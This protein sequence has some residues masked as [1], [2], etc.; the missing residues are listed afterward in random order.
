[1]DKVAY[2]QAMLGVPTKR[3]WPWQDMLDQYARELGNCPEMSKTEWYKELLG[4]TYSG[5][6]EALEMIEAI[7]KVGIPDFGLQMLKKFFT[8]S[9]MPAPDTLPRAMRQV[10]EHLLDTGKISIRQTQDKEKTFRDMLEVA[11]GISGDYNSGIEVRFG[12]RLKQQF[13]EYNWEENKVITAGEQKVRPDFICE[14]LT[15]SIE[16]DGLEFHQDRYS[17]THDRK[18]SRLMQLA[19]YYHLQFSGPELSIPDG[20]T[21]ALNEIAFFIE[22]RKLGEE[23]RYSPRVDP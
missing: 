8:L 12:Q 23:L 17:F 18:K 7:I 13:R 3:V 14:T 20:I 19:G 21:N 9:S 11:E 1:M 15:L 10:R 2:Q 22:H 6:P 4:M 5:S 16:I